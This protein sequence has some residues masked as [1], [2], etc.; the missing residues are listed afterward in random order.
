M[1]RK[2]QVVAIMALVLASVGAVVFLKIKGTDASSN[3]NEDLGARPREFKK[4]AQSAN[5]FWELIE[6]GRRYR[7]EGKLVD[8]IKL[9]QEAHD[10][11]A[12]GN[13]EKP[14]ALIHAAE[15]Y[16]M[17]AEFDKAAVLFEEASKITMHQANKEK[18]MRKSQELRQKASPSVV[19]E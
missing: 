14:I 5:K 15:T 9:F 10:V 18:Y 7:E 17:L 4:H 6:R 11:H 13:I 16:E 19:Q 12:F 2:K 3:A 1:T 8:A